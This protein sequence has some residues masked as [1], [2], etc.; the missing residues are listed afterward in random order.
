MDFLYSIGEKKNHPTRCP[1]LIY[2][3]DETKLGYISKTLR[4]VAG[5][6]QSFYS[7]SCKVWHVPSCQARKDDD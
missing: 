5:H 1:G 4:S 2:I 6:I 3:K 7:I